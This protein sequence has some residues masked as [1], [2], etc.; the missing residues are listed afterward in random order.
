MATALQQT[1][2][3][4]LIAG[5][6]TYFVCVGRLPLERTLAD[7]SSSSQKL[8]APACVPPVFTAAHAPEFFLRKGEF[9]MRWEAVPQDAV[10]GSGQTQVY[11]LAKLDQ[12]A[13]ER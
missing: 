4:A 10:E 1:R 3:I 11:S 12:D 9:H 6:C 13:L 5:I 2:A 8:V 7:E